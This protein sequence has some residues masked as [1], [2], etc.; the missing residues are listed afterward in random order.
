MDDL[1]RR[2]ATGNADEFARKL[3]IS[4]SVLMDNIMDLK[5]F[6]APIVYDDYCCSYKYE[7]DFS[8]FARD[9]A[10]FHNYRG[11]QGFVDSNLFPIR[12][13]RTLTSYF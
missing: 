1:I 3:G 8:L 10:K 7:R 12:Y 4:R 11:G 13:C 5:Q 2:R 9:Y 6:G